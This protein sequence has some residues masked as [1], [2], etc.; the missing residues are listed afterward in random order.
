MTFGKWVLGAVAG[1]LALGAV[2][3]QAA[4]L[5]FVAVDAPASVQNVQF[6]FYAED[7]PPPP[8]VYYDPPPPRY[9]APPPRYYR[10][11]PPPPPTPF[12]GREYGPPRYG[13]YNKEAAKNYVKDYRRAEK[14]IYKERVRAW[15]KANGF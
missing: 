13:Y 5:P 14:E 15:N 11:A 1:G 10:P 7:P 3:A 6:Y 9:Y 4:P 12:Y 8:V 2:S